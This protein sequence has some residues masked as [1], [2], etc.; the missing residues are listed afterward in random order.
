MIPT[1]TILVFSSISIP[2]GWLY[3]DG[4]LISRSIYPNLLKVIG[5][6]FGKG[7][8]LTTFQLPD[9]RGRVIV[10]VGQ[11]PNLSSRFV[12]QQFGSETHTLTIDEMPSHNHEWNLPI[13]GIVN[14]NPPGGAY[15]TPQPLNYNFW[16]Q[17]T[18]GNGAHNN[19]QPSL[20]LS[21]IIKT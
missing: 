3:C 5:D 13:S 20:V 19:M 8:G 1:G 9:L 14:D 4:S 10:G 18:G 11:G 7:D 6:T 15:W 17:N 21:Y 2:D 12:G 16:T